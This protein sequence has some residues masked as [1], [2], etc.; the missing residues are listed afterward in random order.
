MFSSLEIFIT[1]DFRFLF[2]FHFSFSFLHGWDWLND[3]RHRKRSYA[4]PG[5]RSRA[6]SDSTSDGEGR[7]VGDAAVLLGIE[8]LVSICISSKE[9]RQF[10]LRSQKSPGSVPGLPIEFN[11]RARGFRWP[12]SLAVPPPVPC[13]T[14]TMVPTPSRQRL[15]VDIHWQDSW[16]VLWYK[17]QCDRIDPK[18]EFLVIIP[19][20]L[21]R[22]HFHS[23]LRKKIMKSL[24]NSRSSGNQHK[25]NK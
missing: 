15:R 22:R 19:V 20:S 23:K 24:K 18:S 10:I 11:V 21:K 1:T 7:R 16:P 4:L 25:S 13:N 5:R 8:Y 14:G 6:C 3:L 17:M 9:R 2:V 12:V